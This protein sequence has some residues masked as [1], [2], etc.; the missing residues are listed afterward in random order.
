VKEEAMILTHQY[1]EEDLLAAALININVKRV[2]RYVFWS[3][4]VTCVVFTYLMEIS[5]WITRHHID[6]IPLLVPVFIAA[7]YQCQYRLF[8]PRKMRRIFRQQKS[9]HGPIQIEFTETK[10]GLTSSN[11]HAEFPL[12]DFHMWT[13][14]KD[15]IL[16]YH[17][18]S[19][20]NFVPHRA[21]AS[22][23]DFDIAAGYLRNALGK[24]K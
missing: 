16:L 20:Y 18:D 3:V 5:M 15:A 13:K 8:L 14:G 1:T 7:F 2:R 22:Q 12:Q 6:I 23:E 11:G 21:F 4:I 10:F 9:L 19:L 17:S 24:E